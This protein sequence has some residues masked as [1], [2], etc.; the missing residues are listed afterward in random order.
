MKKT[1]Q[2]LIDEIKHIER[3]ISV[4]EDV[5][6]DTVKWQKQQIENFKKEKRNS[7]RRLRRLIRSKSVEL[8][9]L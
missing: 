8:I 7:Q 6:A 1:E 4:L 5:L 2:E 9:K 3:A